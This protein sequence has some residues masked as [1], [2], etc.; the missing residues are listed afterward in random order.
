MTQ[1]YPLAWPD[2]W[3][4]TPYSKRS[5]GKFRTGANGPRINIPE[6]LKRVRYELQRLGV[7]NTEDDMVVSTNLRLNLR[8]DPRG[9]QGEPTDPGVAIYWNEPGKPMRVMASDA[10]FRV[11]DNIAAIAAT[12]EAMRAI[13]RHGGSVIMDRVFSGFT[14]LPP[15]SGERPWWEVLG[16]SRDATPDQIRAAHRDGI[17]LLHPDKHG[18]DEGVGKRAAELNVA[19]DKA[20]AERTL[21]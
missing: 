5:T 12:L 15:P 17:K 19:R 4:R 20:L 7:K 11:A 2:G 21:R 6:A 16:V 8:G 13:E 9:D 14:A 18:G 10:Y 3:K 1:A